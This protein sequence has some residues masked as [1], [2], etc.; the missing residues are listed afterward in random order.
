MTI[1][2]SAIKYALIS[3]QLWRVLEFSTPT[4]YNPKEHL[5]GTWQIDTLIHL[6]SKIAQSP[7][8]VIVGFSLHF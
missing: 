6:A 4:I 3:I 8:P 7:Y 1:F 2:T 5:H